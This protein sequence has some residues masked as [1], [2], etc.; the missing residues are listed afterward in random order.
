MAEGSYQ[1]SFSEENAIYPEASKISWSQPGDKEERASS[2]RNNDRRFG[3]TQHFQK[4][5]Q[6]SE[7]LMH[8]VYYKYG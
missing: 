7:W 2:R 1:A 3:K 5:E 4:T 8:R 6:M